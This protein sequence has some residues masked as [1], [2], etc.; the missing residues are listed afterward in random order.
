MFW[1]GPKPVRSPRPAGLAPLT[2]ALLAGLAIFGAACS[3]YSAGEAQGMLIA[4]R[5]EEQRPD[6]SWAPVANAKIQ[7][8]IWDG[9]PFNSQVS[10]FQE[11]QG[12]TNLDGLA[13][14]LRDAGGK[15]PGQIGM[16]FVEVTHPDGRTGF[17][18]QL[19]DPRF[20]FSKWFEG[21]SPAPGDAEEALQGFCGAA[22][23]F[24][25]C[26]KSLKAN[27]LKFWGLGLLVRIR[28]AA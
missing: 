25:D 15:S 27:G 11:Y 14:E 23:E 1:N 2:A 9:Q 4:A 24:K 19:V 22:R 18:R 21:F 28:A 20:D 17:Q 10:L 13:V 8:Q 6:G 3:D 7:F 26:K 16:L 5:V 12:V